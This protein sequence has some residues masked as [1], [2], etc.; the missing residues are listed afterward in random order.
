VGI[1]WYAVDR[2]IRSITVVAGLVM[3]PAFIG[4]LYSYGILWASIL[5]VGVFVI[6]VGV[7]F[8]GAFNL[9]IEWAQHRAAGGHRAARRRR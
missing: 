1:N 3:I 4:L 7:F 2:H 8:T 6:S 9:F 5:S